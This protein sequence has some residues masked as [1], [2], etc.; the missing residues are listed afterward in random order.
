MVARKLNQ[1]VQVR[2]HPDLNVR[3]D[4]QIKLFFGGFNKLL[5]GISQR[6]QW[7][8]TTAVMQK[9]SNVSDIWCSN[10]QTLLLVNEDLINSCWK[11]HTF[12]TIVDGLQVQ[13]QFQ[14]LI[15]PI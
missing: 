11:G 1:D 8:M 6:V 2:N 7:R 9:H 13:H 5:L 14:D 4:V 3:Q 12:C 15:R 10:K